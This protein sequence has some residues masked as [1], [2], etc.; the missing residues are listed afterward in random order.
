MPCHYTAARLR[1]DPIFYTAMRKFPAGLDRVRDSHSCMNVK[2]TQL[3][4]IEEF[5]WRRLVNRDGLYRGNCY[6]CGREVA[7]Q[8]R[9]LQLLRNCR[10]NQKGAEEESS[11]DLQGF[12]EALNITNG[13]VQET[14]VNTAETPVLATYPSIWVK[15]PKPTDS[16]F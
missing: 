12:H 1:R 14:P 8:L 7:G 2:V 10:K 9:S 6:G 3:L 13:R 11:A 5:V 4:A 15:Q 16:P